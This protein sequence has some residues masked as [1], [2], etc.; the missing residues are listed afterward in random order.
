MPVTCLSGFLQIPAPPTI[1]GEMQQ[2]LG[3]FSFSGQ[4][5]EPGLGTVQRCCDAVKAYLPPPEDIVAQIM[6]A[7][8]LSQSIA[9]ATTNQ[10]ETASEAGMNPV[11]QAVPETPWDHKRLL[12]EEYHSFALALQGANG[13]TD[14]QDPMEVEGVIKCMPSFETMT[15]ALQSPF[16]AV[17]SPDPL[18]I[19]LKEKFEHLTA[20]FIDAA[21]KSLTDI[22]DA[23]VPGFEAF[24]KQ[25]DDV[26][27][28]V[29]KGNVTTITHH[30]LDEQSKTKEALE[31]LQAAK[32]NAE[33]VL[34]GLETMCSHTSGSEPFTKIIATAKGLYKTVMSLSK[35][36]DQIA[37]LLLF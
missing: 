29:E 32:E 13:T 28:A 35:N 33:P 21:D 2:I 17:D 7:M 27:P 30:F 37:G 25:F 36:A 34:K 23:H 19:G 12:S 14:F 26:P 15:S 16:L 20:R 8:G 1:Q 5:V 9:A 10:K 6:A 11:C 18:F 3:S 31:Q 22:Q 4:T 24:M